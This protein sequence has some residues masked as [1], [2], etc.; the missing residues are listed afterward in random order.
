LVVKQGTFTTVD[1]PQGVD[2]TELS[3][4]NATG[5]MVGNFEDSELFFHGFIYKNGVLENIVFPGEDHN[6]VGAVNNNGLI[7]GVV[8]FKTLPS[9][10]YTAMCH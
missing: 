3:D 1:H 10:G 2:G 9:K 6:I 7:A 8:Y 5:V 4:V